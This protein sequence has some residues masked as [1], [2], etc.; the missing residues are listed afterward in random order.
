MPAYSKSMGGSTILAALRA[1]LAENVTAVRRVTTN[2]ELPVE[3]RR[4]IRVEAIADTRRHI[5]EA[6]VAFAEWAKDAVADAKRRYAADPVGNAADETRRMTNE[7]RLGRLVASARA[8]G[9][10]KAV[11]ERYSEDATK[12]Y[13][14]GR[15]DDAIVFGQASLEVGG[16]GLASSRASSAIKASHDQLDAAN[17]ARAAALK[18]ISTA[19][20]GLRVFARDINAALVD[21]YG[22]A[23]SA[24]KAIGDDERE[25]LKAAVGPSMAAKV[26]AMA[27]ANATGVGYVEP[28]GALASAPTGPGLRE[29]GTGGTVTV[30]PYESGH[31][32]RYGA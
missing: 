11:A 27:E 1:K 8:N 18:D 23:A 13:I 21:V 22:L 2:D 19:E 26:A 7:L 15:Y 28:A 16:G 9:T 32:T 6:Q 5:N 24:A 17:P 14:D 12:A 31:V 30:E 3:Y 25:Y 20:A 4:R 29:A 10:P